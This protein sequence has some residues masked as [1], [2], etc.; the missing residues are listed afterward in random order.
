M[1]SRSAQGV[2]LAE[3]LVNKYTPVP[4]TE[5]TGSSKKKIPKENK[6]HIAVT[7]SQE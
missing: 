3:V 4:E 5:G 1:K 7:L 2:G 6:E